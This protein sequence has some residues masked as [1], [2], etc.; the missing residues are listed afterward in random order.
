MEAN[1]SLTLSHCIYCHKDVHTVEKTI[2][3]NTEILFDYIWFKF[4]NVIKIFLNSFFLTE[5]QQ[6]NVARGNCCVLEE[7]EVS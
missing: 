6:K 3:Q 4:W 5:Q 7:K 2:L 1:E